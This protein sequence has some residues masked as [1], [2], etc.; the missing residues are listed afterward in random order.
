MTAPFAAAAAT[1]APFV[2]PEARA[3]NLAGARRPDFIG[4]LLITTAMVG[5]CLA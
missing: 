1:L 2:L 4:G 3:D 5:C